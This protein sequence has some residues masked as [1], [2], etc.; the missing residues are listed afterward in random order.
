MTA[1]NE[2][3][4]ALIERTAG[5]DMQTTAT[6]VILYTVPT[7]KTFYPIAVLVTES[8]LSLAGLTD[9][10]FGTGAL[11]N[12]WRQAVD[13][14]SMTTADTDYME[15]RGADVTKY[16][17]CAAGSEFGLYINTGSTAAAS[18][19]ITVIGLLA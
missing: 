3:S 17:D 4:Y 10:D 16:T 7:G 13:L 5:V 18:A 14:S 12:T 15:I 1:H 11:A 8:D 6:K 2:L 19:V 9:V